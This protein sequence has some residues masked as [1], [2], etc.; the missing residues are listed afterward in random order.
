MKRFNDWLADRF[1][2]WL[3]TMALFWALTLLIVLAL[4][5]QRPSGAQGWVLFV[6]SVFFQGVALPVLAFVSNKQGD[7]MENLLRETH[8]AAM[9]DLEE[10]RQLHEERTQEIENL[11][12]LAKRQ[13]EEIEELKAIHLELAGQHTQLAARLAKAIELPPQP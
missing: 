7:R 3:S 11:K 4:I 6:V 1:A 10:L 5:L 12:D 13:L 2:A 8:D 9:N